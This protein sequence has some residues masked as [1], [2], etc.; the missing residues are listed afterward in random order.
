[1]III[2][3]YIIYIWLLPAT[4]RY[5]RTRQQAQGGRSYTAS[6]CST[7]LNLEDLW[8]RSLGLGASIGS[9][10]NRPERQFESCLAGFH[11]EFP[12]L[13]WV[14]TCFHSGLRYHVALEGRRNERNDDWNRVG[15]DDL[16]GWL[17]KLFG[18]HRNSPWNVGMTFC[19]DRYDIFIQPQAPN[20]KLR[21]E[22]LG[23]QD[24]RWF[25][26]WFWDGV[27]KKNWKTNDQHR[28]THSNNQP[29]L[30]FAKWT[31]MYLYVFE[32]CLNH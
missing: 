7:N 23:V 3:Y 19:Q 29:D 22:S 31:M 14:S 25:R 26:C 13:M 24:F 10:R 27:T 5:E 32:A 6:M 11:A 9:K 17:Q 28:P 30:F 20:V 15:S 2:Y 8:T 16:L 1:M 12:W 21:P 4:E 18:N